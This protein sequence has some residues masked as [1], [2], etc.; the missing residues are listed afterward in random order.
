MTQKHEV[1]LGGTVSCLKQEGSFVHVTLDCG[2]SIKDPVVL[3]LRKDD[4]RLESLGIN[5]RFKLDVTP[6]P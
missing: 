5:V 2:S 6:T 3:I 1:K 4:E